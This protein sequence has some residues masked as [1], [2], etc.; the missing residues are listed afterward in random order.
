MWCRMIDALDEAQGVW[1]PTMT[2]GQRQEKMFEKL[3][4]SGLE[5]WP[6]ELTESA[7]LLLAEYHDLFSLECGEL[8]CTHLTEHVIKVTNDASFKE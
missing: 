8:G 5:S 7:H 6:P 4:L 3:D 2:T 1:A